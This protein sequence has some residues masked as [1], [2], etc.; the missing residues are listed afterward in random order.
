M[1]MMYVCLIDHG[2]KIGEIAYRQNFISGFAAQ[3]AVLTLR[4]LKKLP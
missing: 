1:M 3:S 2:A 4:I